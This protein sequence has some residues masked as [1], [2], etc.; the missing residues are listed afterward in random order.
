MTDQGERAL[1]VLVTT[2][3]RTCSAAITSALQSIDASI[4]YQSTL[5][6]PAPIDRARAGDVLRFTNAVTTN[7]SLNC[8]VLVV[9]SQATQRSQFMTKR[10]S[11][12]SIGV[13]VSSMVAGTA[14]AA[15]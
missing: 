5:M 14:V 1:H 2:Y 3:M 15:Q 10:T 8:S 4:V 12:P 6:R 7:R 13:L 9:A 11:E